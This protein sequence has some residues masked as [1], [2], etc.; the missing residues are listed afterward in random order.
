MPSRS[1]S[2]AGVPAEASASGAW[3]PTAS[4]AWVN[5]SAAFRLPHMEPDLEP[6]SGG[7][8]GPEVGAQRQRIQTDSD[9]SQEPDPEAFCDAA[10]DADRGGDDTPGRDR[11]SALV[12]TISSQGGETPHGAEVTTLDIRHVPKAYSRRQLM[13]V[14]DSLGYKNEYDFVYLPRPTPAQRVQGGSGAAPDANAGHAFVNFRSPSVASRCRQELSGHPFPGVRDGPAVEIGVAPVQGYR[15]NIQHYQA[16]AKRREEAK[17]QDA[18]GVVAAEST[19]VERGRS[20]E[21]QVTIEGGGD[22]HLRVSVTT[23]AGDEWEVTLP[24]EAASKENAE[25]AARLIK[26]RLQKID[27]LRVAGRSGPCPGPLSIAAA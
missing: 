22:A 11:D 6:R 4:G 10:E 20:E 17:K 14:L 25:A 26:Q 16:M 9:A 21:P 15:E 1:A 24:P 2:Q 8:F 18:D 7:T 23:A 5:P 12:T 13:S 27:A 19:A 3:V